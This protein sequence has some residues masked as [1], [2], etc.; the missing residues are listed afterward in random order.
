ML[1]TPRP[2]LVQD[3]KVV[4][5]LCFLQKNWSI[6]HA[7]EIIGKTM[8][9]R[10]W[11]HFLSQCKG[12]NLLQPSVSRSVD[13]GPT[14][15]PSCSFRLGHWVKTKYVRI[16]LSRHL[17][18]AVWEHIDCCQQQDSH[19]NCMQEQIRCLRIMCVWLFV[20]KLAYV[21][22]AA[23]HATKSFF[24]KS[25]L[26]RLR[27]ADL[28]HMWALSLRTLQIAF[29]DCV[30]QR[31]AGRK[32]AFGAVYPH[33]KLPNEEAVLSYFIYFVLPSC[34]N[35]S[36][37]AVRWKMGTFFGNYCFFCNFVA[38]SMRWQRLLDFDSFRYCPTTGESN[39]IECFFFPQV[40]SG[41]LFWK[42]SCRKLVV[43]P[44]SAT[45]VQI[46][47]KSVRQF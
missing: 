30:S 47:S 39:W 36:F 7:S 26:K 45:V 14:C 43:S 2:R 6:P 29:L 10:Q 20:Q 25:Y 12:Q 37:K 5:A 13:H 15:R 28:I 40:P 42:Q 23:G 32:D 18:T 44:P 27:S 17:I 34:S 35:V 41:K 19:W 1:Q 4:F 11:K 22:K 31:N 46:V 33:L 9:P 8:S 24:T 16:Q 3:R 38:N 21:N